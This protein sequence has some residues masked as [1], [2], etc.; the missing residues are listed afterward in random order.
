MSKVKLPKGEFCNVGLVNRVPQGEMAYAPTMGRTFELADGIYLDAAVGRKRDFSLGRLWLSVGTTD[1]QGHGGKY[2]QPAQSFSFRSYHPLH[3]GPRIKLD[4]VEADSRITI[5][6]A[7]LS[8]I[9]SQEVLEQ[10]DLGSVSEEH[11]E[12]S[13]IG[14]DSPAGTSYFPA[15]SVRDISRNG[16]SVILE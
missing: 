16:T 9:A 1:L 14:C 12:I 10:I 2:F 5:G 7:M 4:P 8:D 15:L 6:S 3:E 13:L 11:L